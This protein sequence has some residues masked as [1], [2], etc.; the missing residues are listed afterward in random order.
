MLD[1]IRDHFDS[2]P[3]GVADRLF[4]RRPVRHDAR[5]FQRLGNP[6]SVILPIELN[7]K[8]HAS[9]VTGLVLE[10]RPARKVLVNFLRLF[11]RVSAPLRLPPTPPP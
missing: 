3:F 10:I 1:T 5:Q 2:E 7:G 11:L 9:I 4:G 6:P 8:M